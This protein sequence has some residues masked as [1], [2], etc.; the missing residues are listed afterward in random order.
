MPSWP[1]G[2]DEMWFVALAAK[3][4]EDMDDD[5]DDESSSADFPHRAT[6]SHVPK[7]SNEVLRV[8]ERGVVHLDFLVLLDLFVLVLVPRPRTPRPRRRRSR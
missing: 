3:E 4:D 2:A 8:I 7:D 6:S 1:P 5:D